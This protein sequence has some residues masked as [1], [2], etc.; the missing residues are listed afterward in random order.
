MHDNTELVDDWRA[1]QKIYRAFVRVGGFVAFLLMLIIIVLKNLYSSPTESMISE[2]AD[3]IIFELCLLCSGAFL[4]SSLIGIIFD[5]YQTR[6]VQNENLIAKRFIEEGII[7]VFK[8]A[9]DP[10]LATFI[11]RLIKSTKSEII[12]CGLGLGLLAHNRDILNAISNRLNEED[13]VRVSIYFGSESNVGVQNRIKEE[14]ECHLKLGINYD[15]QWVTRYPAEIESVLS[16][17]VN[18]N[19]LNRLK[20]KKTA[21][22]PM[23]SVIKFDDIYLFFSYGTPDIRGSQSPWIAIKGTSTQSEFAHFLK[24][25]IDYYQKES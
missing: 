16:R 13:N 19:A 9:N 6:F 21:V 1:S 18:N 7:R 24:R 2:V 3:A 4:A 23:L 22:C 20:I 14:K 17:S 12:A 8:S 25:N 15:D 10:N 11:L 5:Q